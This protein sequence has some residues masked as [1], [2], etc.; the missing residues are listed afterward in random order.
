MNTETPGLDRF[1]FWL[2]CAML[3]LL[4]VAVMFYQIRYTTLHPRDGRVWV[5]WLF[6]ASVGYSG[7]RKLRHKAKPEA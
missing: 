3:A 4:G 1:A 5:N 7:W 6:M 2:A